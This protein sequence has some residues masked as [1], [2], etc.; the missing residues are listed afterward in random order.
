MF[1]MDVKVTG[2]NILSNASID[3]GDAAW[4]AALKDG[5]TMKVVDSTIA[6]TGISTRPI[7]WMVFARTLPPTS[8]L[9]Y[10]HT[11]VYK[12]D[13]SAIPNYTK[14]GSLCV[15]DEVDWV[16]STTEG[17]VLHAPATNLCYLTKWNSVTLNFDRP[18][19]PCS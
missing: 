10:C 9:A 11:P 15:T 3:V 8:R 4:L 12:D 7:V 2:T 14:A 6:L 19:T 17:L 18:L 5:S 16:V 13:G 1:P